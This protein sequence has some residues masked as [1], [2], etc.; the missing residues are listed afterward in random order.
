MYD[1]LKIAAGSIGPMLLFFLLKSKLPIKKRM[2]PFAI[3]GIVLLIAAD[4][5]LIVND[6]LLFEVL[7]IS[8]ALYCL[9]ALIF[10]SGDIRQRIVWA[11]V[12]L[13][14]EWFSG[15]FSRSVLYALPYSETV[16][17]FFIT[18]V[19]KA[20]LCI[21]VSLPLILVPE[22]KIR[23]TEKAYDAAIAGLAAS[24]ASMYLLS[25]MAVSAAEKGAKTAALAAIA[26]IILALDVLLIILLGKVSVWSERYFEERVLSESLKRE[27]LYNSE[28]K[29][30][31]QSV[32]QLKHDYANHMSVI[33]SLANG[34][35]LEG[36]REYMA[37]YKS[38]YG[39]VERFALTGDGMLDSL[40]SYKMMICDAEG[41][42]FDIT[43]LGGS[44]QS[45][46]LSATEL[47]SL[48]GNL[49]DNAINA[50]R[51]LPPERRRIELTIRKMADMLCIT[52]KNETVGDA[53]AKK[54]GD[55]RGLGVPRIKR[56]V[57]AHDGVCTLT[58]G[59][60]VFTAEVLL[61]AAFREEVLNET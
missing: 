6:R 4:V 42:V 29:T 37:D 45:T 18:S 21:L 55:H 47:S 22:K 49:I 2:L 8:L 27:A 24:T 41:I 7:M 10:F 5:F 25:A 53:P 48:F 43:A 56:I 46:G 23:M 54:K 1:A 52:V 50:C 16:S 14:I 30:V 31:V 13:L 51:L 26:L 9:Y 58:P 17:D 19:L 61:P 60:D 33:A 59:K 39:S 15:A 38:E 11:L 40:L 20:A 35:D 34:G 3:L 44:V 32:R 57:E 36:L 12:M 28:M